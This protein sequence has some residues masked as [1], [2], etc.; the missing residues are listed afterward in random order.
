MV[1]PRELIA[2]FEAHQQT[3]CEV[4]LRSIKF[5]GPD[6]WEAIGDKIGNCLKVP[7]FALGDVGCQVEVMPS[8]LAYLKIDQQRDFARRIM[9]WVPPS[10]LKECFFDNEITLIDMRR[11]KEPSCY[12]SP[13]HLEQ[14]AYSVCRRGF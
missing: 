2:L 12:Q 14:R 7:Y 5:L 3:L 13:E 11:V 4:K 10:D 6:S 1:L 9:R 8:H